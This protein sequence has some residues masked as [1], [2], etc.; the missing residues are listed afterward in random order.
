[1]S[2]PS[3][4]QLGSVTGYRY[5]GSNG[6][7][8]AAWD[9][10]GSTVPVPAGTTA[11]Y[12][13]FGT[14]LPLTSTVTLS[15]YPTYFLAPDPTALTYTGPAGGTSGGLAQLSVSLTDSLT[16]LPVAGR[17]VRLTVGGR[18]CSAVTDVS[19]AA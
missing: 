4:V 1:R 13:D 15:S 7:V 14:P 16:H 19:G 12:D 3:L 6:N 18:S 9:D 8:T 5:A 17:S 2:V 11:I 10:A